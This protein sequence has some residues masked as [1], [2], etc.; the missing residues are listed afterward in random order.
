MKVAIL[1]KGPTLQKFSGIDGEV[2][3]LNQLGRSHNLDRLFVMDDLR[4]RM[5]IWDSELPEFLKGYDKPIYTSRV[6][7]EFKTSV[8]YPLA[9][10]SKRFG[11][12][13][14][15]SFYSTVDYM[16]AL[17]VYEGYDV[18]D[19]YGVDCTQPKREER[20]RVSIA[21]WITVAQAN[22]IEVRAQSG[23]FF[24]WFTNTGTV[25]EH[26]LYG[27]VGT[28]RIEELVA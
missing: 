7:P 23:S 8:E 17:A 9:D 4:I 28:P 6:Y 2:W 14:G 10:V 26:A 19:L 22:G 3:G 12:P 18:I 16:I 21:R 13:L 27:Y 1:A 25:Y 15:I 24:S 20:E 11:V 5:P